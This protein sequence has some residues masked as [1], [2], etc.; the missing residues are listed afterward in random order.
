[1]HVLSYVVLFLSSIIDCP[2][3]FIKVLSAT[4]Q[5]NLI[6][7]C[8]FNHFSESTADGPD[9]SVQADV[10]EIKLE[11]NNCEEIP[12]FTNILNRIPN[13]T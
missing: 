8:D 13:P 7:P 10:L 1:M 4:W 9:L 5:Q 11:N 6:T 2:L 12:P 3:S